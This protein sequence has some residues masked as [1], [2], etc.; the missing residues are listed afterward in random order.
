M[1][2]NF[3][4]HY[5]M[6][7]LRDA[8]TLFM[9][10]TALIAAAMFLPEPH[11]LRGGFSLAGAGLAMAGGAAVIWFLLRY[12]HRALILR[13]AIPL[14]E[15]ETAPV[16][17]SDGAGRVLFQNAQ[18][19]RQYRGTTLAQV[20][21]D[22]AASPEAL[23]VRLRAHAAATGQASEDVATRRGVITITVRRLG[24]GVLQW[25]MVSADQA[26]APDA[27]ALPLPM[28][29]LSRAGAITYCNAALIDLLGRRP[30]RLEEV[31]GWS[32]A[33]QLRLET[34]QGPRDV[35]VA[36]FALPDGGAQ[37]CL[38]PR[39]AAAATAQDDPWGIVED[40]PVA[41]IKLSPTGEILSANRPARQLLRSDMPIGARI[42]D[43]LEGL[44]RP[45]SDWV[46]EALKSPAGAK[47]QFLRG[48]GENRDRVVQVTLKPS[49]NR[50]APHL[51][52]VLHN[53]TEFKALEAQFVQSQKMQAIGQ[54]AG[55]VAHDFNNLLTAI[56]GHC[57]LL[58]LRHEDGDADYPDLTQIRQNTN[59]AAGL[60][61]QLL[62]FSRKQD[63]KLVPL[64]LRDTLADLTHLLNRLVGEKVRLTL[65]H[66]PAP[67]MVLAD[68]R[69]LEQVIMNLVVNARDAMAEGGE[70]RI[71]A[72]NLHLPAP[73]T[74]D[75]ATVQAGDYV[76]VRVVDEGCGIP[77]EM[78]SHVFEPFYTT[79]GVG[80]GT[81][82][83]LSTAYGIVKQLGGFIFID[84]TPGEGAIFSVYLPAREAGEIPAR[85]KPAAPPVAETTGGTVLLV[86][87]EAPVRAFAARALRL[88]GHEVIEADSGEAALARLEDPD[89]RID[90]FV[91]DVVMPGLDG[92]GWVHRAL[93]DRP[94]TPTVFMSGYAEDN[95]R[96]I[97]NRV[98]DSSYLPKPFSLSEL[99]DL[100]AEQISPPP[101]A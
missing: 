94:G 96:E 60:V 48:V 38:L 59:R 84:S 21:R 54:L 46:S 79:K 30:A 89:L 15:T 23:F 61:R 91:T 31:E 69:Q 63:L 39:G 26:A 10:G 78:L 68:K 37:I 17:F 58:L 44:G 80:E 20:W 98:P 29:Q 28:V 40:L 74:R 6:P 50:Q 90:L 83:G 9:L 95:L 27:D 76:V 4:S 56:A 49:A 92:P 57:D 35:S 3:F 64:D 43:L 41:L 13:A 97:R 53:A 70:V 62:A 52:G 51:I 55:G 42:G 71:E 14:S 67:L 22:V 93:K 82:L 25:R 33:P 101:E 5:R 100:V 77:P 32:D 66:D 72:E 24:A 47:P 99:T 18:A 73:L 34:R 1:S 81:G 19:R 8:G 85:A 45:V 7:R 11:G 16:L 12:A 86:E 2:Q 75:R 65:I 88:R 87:D 36:R